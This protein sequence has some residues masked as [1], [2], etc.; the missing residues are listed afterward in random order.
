MNEKYLVGDVVRIALLLPEVPDASHSGDGI[1]ELGL[2]K[3][4]QSLNF[5]QPEIWALDNAKK[6]YSF[7]PSNT[8]KN[9]SPIIVESSSNRKWQLLLQRAVSWAS[10][11]LGI[12]DFLTPLMRGRDVRKLVESRKIDLVVAY[13]WHASFA[14]SSVACRRVL[15]LGDPLGEGARQ[16]SLG[17]DPH[18][19]KK[20]SLKS[21]LSSVL[22][23]TLL[24]GLMKLACS[25]AE[26]FAFSAFHAST[27]ST[28][29]QRH[30][31]YLR[32]PYLVDTRAKE[33]R[34]PEK[35][36][37][38]VLLMGQLL[39]T[40]TTQGL[41]FFA[42]EVLPHLKSGLADKTIEIRI[43]GGP[44]WAILDPRFDT[45]RI[46]GVEFVGQVYPP[47]IEMNLATVLVVPTSLPL[48]NRVR[49]LT[50]WDHGLPVIA[51][52]ANAS[53]IPELCSGRNVLLPQS[54]LQMA[55]QILS[56]VHNDDLL[57]S[58]ADGGHAT[59]TE[60]FAESVVAEELS[61]IL[62][63]TI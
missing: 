25:G 4:M 23:Q 46:P 63:K 55:Q 18:S 31:P 13:H 22:R 2:I 35:E 29:L 1:T 54:G 45:L 20:K 52:I 39:G 7:E 19:P 9:L 16:L 42:N 56:L 17:F 43:A 15:L 58:L 40:A 30:V 3:T 50:A 36:P 44:D 26:V 6:R 24:R 51:H 53:G 41:Q 10:H 33:S 61:S 59:L 60:Y 62:S 14:S 32:T 57:R 49:I 37:K 28:V 11:R 48:G 34:R 27:Y 21:K 38:R 12:G 5:P 47:G 8:A